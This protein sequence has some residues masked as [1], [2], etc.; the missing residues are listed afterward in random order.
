VQYPFYLHQTLLSPCAAYSLDTSEPPLGY[1]PLVS[2]HYG[3]LN[4]DNLPSGISGSTTPSPP[5]TSWPEDIPTTNRA[6]NSSTLTHASIFHSQYI[7]STYRD[8]IQAPAISHSLACS[9]SKIT[10][11]WA[12]LRCALISVSPNQIIIIVSINNRPVVM[13]SVVK[14]NIPGISD[15]LG[16]YF[17]LCRYRTPVPPFLACMSRSVALWCTDWCNHQRMV[18]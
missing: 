15:S 17:P 4:S 9:P 13:G 1:L 7:L 12:R 6:S 8:R 18:N 3:Q 2:N 10:C 14:D 16:A 11:T 5:I